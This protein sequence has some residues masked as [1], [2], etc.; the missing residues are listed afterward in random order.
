ME[1]TE[2]RTM[3]ANAQKGERTP[4]VLAQRLLGGKSPSSEQKKVIDTF[5]G[6]ANIKLEAVA[7]AGKST[8]LLLCAAATAQRCVILTYNKRLQLDTKARIAASELPNVEIRTYH[9]AA[10]YV[11]ERN[12]HNDRLLI[13]AV[14]VAPT[15]RLDCEVLMLDEAQDLTIEYFLF[16]EQLLAQ[17]TTPPQLLVVGDARQM[18][19]AFKGARAEFL[20]EAPR[21]FAANPRP[22]ATC[23]L[24]TS[25]R[26]T[27][28][29]ANFV[30]T[31][32]L[33]FPLITGGN[34]T[35]PAGKPYYVGTMYGGAA[36]DLNVQIRRLLE[37][38]APES[39]VIAAPSV[40]AI[41]NNAK[42][43]LA[44]AIK[45][46]LSDVPL[47]VAASDEDELDERLTEGKLVLCSW[48][49]TKGREWPCV[50][51]VTFDELYLKYYEREWP[52]T[53]TYIP[54]IMYV[55]A[56]RSLDEL[57]ILADDR[58]TL[59]TVDL[60]RLADDAILAGKAPRASAKRASLGKKDRKVGVT[61]LL[62]H[63]DG[64]TVYSML[65]FVEG[66]G[67]RRVAAPRQKVAS[68]VR[69]ERHHE[70]VAT[71]YGIVIPALAELQRTG[72]TSFGATF[73]NPAI[74]DDD[75][76]PG[77]NEI[78]RKTHQ[79]YPKDF[80]TKVGA[81]YKTSPKARTLEDWFRL[82]V[83]CYAMHEN[84]HHIAR[85]IKHYD[86]IDVEF[87]AE[88]VECTKKALTGIS[89][90]FEVQTPIKTWL[91]PKLSLWGYADFVADASGR[92][93][94]CWEFKCVEELADEHVLQ[95]A[96]YVALLGLTKGCLYAIK[97]GQILTIRVTNPAA[98]LGAAV[99]KYEARD[100]GDIASDIEAFR[101]TLAI[102]DNNCAQSTDEPESDD[103]QSYD[104][105]DLVENFAAL[106]TQTI[107]RPK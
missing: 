47:Y 95:L 56:T 35:S 87:V 37:R 58:A 53:A 107:R 22:W 30:N 9:G 73:H 51:L 11:Y 29:V 99:K 105:G 101:Q 80:W 15:R 52:P 72:T 24:S 88:A 7:G 23:Q 100:P 43:P 17:Q 46:F 55:A 82:A 3:A 6:G 18:I 106:A 49:S 74:V 70:S 94:A 103:I 67:E 19:N 36:R 42:N 54:N 69:F 48:N 28:G 41:K 89:G 44:Q 40:R 61:D 63:M 92:P 5:V 8:T 31:H 75:V 10:S 66:C 62:R 26:L 39:I 65:K 91:D 79:S 50:I 34:T 60:A 78:T 25:Y 98:L 104:I 32:V 77:P 102:G 85:Q 21:L 76:H 84:M 2:G 14:K 1:E 59:R 4:S 86:W 13:D 12:I 20:A 38:H 97:S 33:G 71:L 64:P 27:P 57:V 96:C 68:I 16:V 83:A 93:D 45:D 90:R 81:A